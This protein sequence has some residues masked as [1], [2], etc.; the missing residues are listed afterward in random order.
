MK[1]VIIRLIG[2]GLIIASVVGLVFSLVG[3]YAVW[4]YKDK[5]TDSL[6]NAVGLLVTTLEATSAGLSV[7]DESLT[8]A[9][10]D[11]TALATTLQTT[12][13]SIKD[14]SPLLDT[15]RVMVG[16][17]L[18]ATITS[19]QFA[20][21]SAQGSAR[22]IESTLKIITSIPLLPLESYNPPIPLETALGNVAA[23]LEALPESFASMEESLNTSQDNLVLIVAEFNNM[24]QQV[25]EINTSLT[26]ARAV[27]GQYQLVVITLNQQITGLQNNLPNWTNILAWFFTFALIWLAL[28]Q[29]GLLT[30]GAEM[31]GYRTRPRPVETVNLAPEG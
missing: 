15:I 14:T 4:K 21:N 19:T 5:A 8:K 12:G 16:E 17:D 6:S 10:T 18:P 9:T 11:V 23:S 2:I 22:L 20:L 30:Q 29:L 25:E 28:T 24:A 27:I 31:L 1:Q 13:K 3:A 26:D 7:A